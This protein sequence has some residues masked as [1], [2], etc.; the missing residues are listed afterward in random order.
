MEA[1]W[2]YLKDLSFSSSLNWFL[3]D[4]AGGLDIITIKVILWVNYLSLRDV[5][6]PEFDS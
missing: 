3:W 4:N 6:C 1:G 5:Q 2:S